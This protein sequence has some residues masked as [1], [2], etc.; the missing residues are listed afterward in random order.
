M[1]SDVI[2]SAAAFPAPTELGEWGIPQGMVE[3]YFG[4]WAMHEESFHQLRGVVET[5]DLRQHVRISIEQQEAQPPKSAYDLAADYEVTESKLGV[6]PIVGTLTKYRSSFSQGNSTILLQAKIRNAL[7]NER[8]RAIVLKIDS[9]GGTAAGTREVAEAVA[10]AN[11]QKP[12]FAYIDDL[13]ASAAYWI[14]SQASKV[15]VNATGMLPSIGTYGVVYDYSAQASMIGVKTHVIRAGAYKGM[16]APG[17]EVTAEQLAEWQRLIDGLNDFFIRGVARGRKMTLAAV[18]QLADGR[19]HI[20][21]EAVELGLADAVQ[22]FEETLGQLAPKR[23]TK[24]KLMS[25]DTTTAV[26]PTTL[27]E[28][29]KACAGANS[30]WLLAQLE[31]EATLDQARTAWSQEQDRRLKAA[32]EETAKAK[33]DAEEAKKAAETRTE[34][35]GVQPVGAGLGKAAGGGDIDDAEQQWHEAVNANCKRFVALGEPNN[36]ARSH[37]VT[38]AKRDNPELHEAYLESYTQRHGRPNPRRR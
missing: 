14:A 33:A 23:S 3:Q 9:P 6:I 30:D 11:K 10:A 29:K 1:P 16:G 12:V 22:T 20:G 8:V 7:A 17:T 36:A 18:K 15:F 34:G 4:P 37:A 26:Q 19:V 27:A 13:G 35:D 32:Q 5:M 28:L 24:G 2:E 31:N 38:Q 25:E 21:A